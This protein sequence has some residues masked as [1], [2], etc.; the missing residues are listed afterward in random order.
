M[1]G[2][3]CQGGEGQKVQDIEENVD[4]VKLFDSEPFKVNISLCK[5]MA[6]KAFLTTSLK[7]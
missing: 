1:C 5:R 2:Q 6:Q 3:E 4:E 7:A